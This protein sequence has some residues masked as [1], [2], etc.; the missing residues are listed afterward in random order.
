MALEKSI[1]AANWQYS[2][3]IIKEGNIQY[4]IKSKYTLQEHLRAPFVSCSSRYPLLEHLRA[5]NRSDSPKGAKIQSCLKRCLK[6]LMILC[7]IS[8]CNKG[9]IW[10]KHHEAGAPHW[11]QELKRNTA[12]LQYKKGHLISCK[13]MVL[14][15]IRSHEGRR[16]WRVAAAR[17]VTKWVKW[18]GRHQKSFKHVPFIIKSELFRNSVCKHG[19]GAIQIC[20]LSYFIFKLK[21]SRATRGTQ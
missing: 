7:K 16:C 13:Q 2:D 12:T 1:Q 15:V 18:E 11:L 10:K 17:K 3:K 4:L 20:L 8:H 19:K 5:P 9:G 14:I 6:G 21:F